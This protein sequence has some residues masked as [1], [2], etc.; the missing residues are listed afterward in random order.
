[1]KTAPQTSLGLIRLI[2]T[3]RRRA[4]IPEPEVEPEM[5]GALLV[6]RGVNPTRMRKGKSGELARRGP[7]P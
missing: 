3:V 1:M 7:R 4:V 2:S 6:G 5:K